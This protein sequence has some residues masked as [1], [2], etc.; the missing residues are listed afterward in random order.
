MMSMMIM[1]NEIWREITHS[2]VGDMNRNALMIDINY[3]NHHWYDDKVGEEENANE[4]KW[5]TNWMKVW[6]C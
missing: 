5:S 6:S 1:A 2:K 3:S 4:N